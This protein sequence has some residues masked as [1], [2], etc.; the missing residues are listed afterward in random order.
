M[1]RSNSR[2]RT[3]AV[4]TTLALAALLSVSA[5]TV[6]A[7]GADGGQ[8]TADAADV[9]DTVAPTSPTNFRLASRTRSGQITLRWDASSDNVAV[10]GYSMY[11]NGVWAGTLYQAGVD[12]IGTVWYDRLGGRTK[13]PVTY[14]LYAFDAAGNTS[15]PATLVVT[16]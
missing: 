5:T 15:A 11:R 3:R 16:P 8:A 6:Q 4:I 2:S 12:Q 7:A 13:T 9:P 14:E 10:A 1:D